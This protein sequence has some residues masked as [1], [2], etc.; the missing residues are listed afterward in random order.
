[1]QGTSHGMDNATEKANKIEQSQA[2]VF[3]VYSRREIVFTM[4]GVYLIMFLVMMDQTVVG[5]AMPRI[6]ADLQGFDRI[7]WVTTAYLL[8]STVTIPVYGKLSDVFGR[9][10]L[11]LLGIVV[12][13]A[14]SALSGAAHSLNQLIAFRAFQGL[15]AGALEPIAFTVV[16]DLFPPRERG[17]WQGLTGSV[18]GLGA[19]IG[20]LFGG[21]ITDHTSWRWVFYVNI[22]LGIVALL[23]LLFLMPWIRST[24]KQVFVDYV[25]SALLIAGTVAILLGFSLVNVQYGWLSFPILSLFATGLVLVTLLVFYEARLERRGRESV[26]EP[27]LFR[28]SARIFGVSLFI[29]MIIGMGLY[30]A[31]FAIP[32]FVQGV[33]GASATNSGFILVPFMLTSIAGSVVSGLFIS[34]FGKYKWLA[35]LGLIVSILGSIML[36]GLNIHSSDTAVLLAMVVLGFGVGSGLTIYTVATQN[37]LPQ[38]MGQVTSTL[39]FFRQLGGTMGLA[40]MESILNAT[41]LPAFRQALPT[42]VK[43]QLPASA[44]AVFNNPLV[45][46]SPDAQRRLSASYA[47]YGSKGIAFLHLV[48]TAMKQGLA[49][50][51]HDVFVF[52][53]L[54]MIV[55]L[56][57]A[58]F[59]KEIPLRRREARAE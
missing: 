5:T 29:N 36:V 3:R 55:G 56:V 25:G 35:L 6:V 49:Q 21:W 46:L 53:L 22:P 58:S 59:L 42:L 31:S 8:T 38:K 9:K 57:L 26:F 33:N 24:V 17:K 48:Q 28:S 45:L 20:P 27:G 15:G 34:L 11:F 39:T 50:G 18:Y 51:T 13:I 30:G 23:V 37:A 16:G 7:A 44:L 47:A 52:T 2:Q 1:M 4:I 14:G 40:V 19:I 41:Y 10:P 32:L 54:L 12:F 43:Q